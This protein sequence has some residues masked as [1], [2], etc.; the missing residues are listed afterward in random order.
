M[1]T[2]AQTVEGCAN[3][4]SD[5]C[6]LNKSKAIQQ[7]LWQQ[8]CKNFFFH[9]NHSTIYIF[10]AWTYNSQFPECSSARPGGISSGPSY[11]RLSS[12]FWSNTN[13]EDEWTTWATF[14]K[15]F[16]ARR[17]IEVEELIEMWSLIFCVER[18]QK[19][20]WNGA[21]YYSVALTLYAVTSIVIC[22]KVTL[23]VNYC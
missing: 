19:L 8:E 18:R 6:H 7:F 11:R 14:L 3:N 16:R 2:V 5:T 22:L 10:Q 9:E 15:L 4:I 17:Q 20:M 13:P 1:D 23:P 12:W 21:N